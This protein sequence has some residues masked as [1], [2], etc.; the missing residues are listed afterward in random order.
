MHARSGL[1][2]EYLSL[3]W[4]ECVRC[5]IQK[6]EE[7][8]MDVWAYD[9]EGWPSGFAG[10]L[11]PAMSPDYHAKFMTMKR[12]STTAG[13]DRDSVIAFTSIRRNTA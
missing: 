13:L 5:G 3:E 9:E 11:V 7:M 8:D 12:C 10:G 6:G 2:I 1:K 4:F